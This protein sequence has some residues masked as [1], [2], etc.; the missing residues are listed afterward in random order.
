M[1]ICN[2]WRQKRTGEDELQSLLDEVEKRLKED[3][4]RAVMTFLDNLPKS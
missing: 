2:G 3:I 4:K 1:I